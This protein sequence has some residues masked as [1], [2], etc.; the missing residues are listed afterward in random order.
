MFSLLTSSSS[1]HDGIHGT[2]IEQSVEVDD[3]NNVLSCT[4]L[5]I[6]PETSITTN[7]T[8]QR[9]VSS[10]DDTECGRRIAHIVY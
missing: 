3:N 7:E 4:S 9:R 10:V 5:P 2:S 1:I 6:L 8:T